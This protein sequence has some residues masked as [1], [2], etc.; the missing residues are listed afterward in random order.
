MSAIFSNTLKSQKLH[1]FLSANLK[2]INGTV[3]LKA[4]ASLRFMGSKLLLLVLL[5]LSVF[6]LAW[7]VWEKK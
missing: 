5:H 6:Q 3:L 2:T 7:D 1:R 4:R